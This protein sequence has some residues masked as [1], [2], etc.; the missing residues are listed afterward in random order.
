MTLKG[1]GKGMLKILLMSRIILTKLWVE[2][3]KHFILFD[4]NNAFYWYWGLSLQEQRVFKN[5]NILVKWFFV[6]FAFCWFF[7]FCCLF[8]CYGVVFGNQRLVTVP[9]FHPCSHFRVARNLSMKITVE[10][11]SLRILMLISFSRI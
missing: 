7:F 11:W 4:N 10:S 9:L 5:I 2:T 6:A 1:S 3:S 8:R